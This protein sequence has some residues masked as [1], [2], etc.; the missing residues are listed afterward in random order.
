MNK[1]LL[2]IK[3]EYLT[4]VKK[5]S[6]LIMTILGPV[7]FGGLMFGAVAL[8]LQDSASYEVLIVDKA[9]AISQF[10]STGRG[11]ESR[12][13]G[14]FRYNE[15]M[16][17]NYSFLDKEIGTEGFKN[18]PYS[19]MIEID[20]AAANN[21]PCNFYFKKLP[22]EMASSVIKTEI[23][24]AVEEFRVTGSLNLKFEDYKRI[25]VDIPF[26]EINIEKLGQEDR[27]TEKAMVGF[28]FAVFIY[29]FIFM[30]G[31]Q[32]MRGVI[33]EKTNRIIEVI[34]SSVKPFQLMM[35]KVIGI[36]LVGLTQFL[37]WVL[38]SVIIF[39]VAQGLTA[40]DAIATQ[41]V[42]HGTVTT[43]TAQL[44]VNPEA[45]SAMNSVF[46]LIGEINW[47]LLIGMFLFFFIGGFLLY[48][49]LFAAIGAAVDNETDTQQFMAPVTIPLVFG[50]IVAEFMI[51][52]PAGGAANIFSLVPLTSPVVM[53]V[54][55]A[56]TGHLT[57]QMVLSMLILI[58][59]FV[60]TIWLAGRIYRVGI[61][62]YGKKATYRELWKW[63]TYKS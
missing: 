30:Y 6:F 27:T 41:M 44:P 17:I 9:G 42:D 48:S 25:K 56:M 14:R 19:V 29:L 59:T 58:A 22:S 37:I 40:P 63:I 32:V 62:M 43:T 49:S 47:P 52:N 24:N 13:P 28:V 7:L 35:G 45:N 57:M 15:E 50:F 26:R 51:A 16:K 11:F 61:L 20:D 33:E 8:A 38:F 3:R 34:I 21:A 4:R 1:I 46:Q 18:S 31:I 2:I 54:K 55:V 39:T 53:M 5:K 12:F 10:D 36:G 23:E 60:G